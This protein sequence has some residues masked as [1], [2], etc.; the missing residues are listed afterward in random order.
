MNSDG[1]ILNPYTCALT[2][3]NL[4]E[5]GAGTGKTYN[6]Q[7]LVLRKLL[8]AEEISLRNIL[9]VTFT[10]DA[11]AELRTRLRA[12]LQEMK[13][14]CQSGK[15]ISD[16]SEN[17]FRENLLTASAG[18]PGSQDTALE[19]V[20]RALQIF[21]EA[22]IYTIHSFCQRML[23]INA[24]ESGIRYGLEIRTDM[25]RMYQELLHE[26]Y[27]EMLFRHEPDSAWYWKF[28]SLP[29][30]TDFELVNT[31]LSALET[32]MDLAE[33][34]KAFLADEPDFTSADCLEKLAR[35]L[36][37]VAKAIDAQLTQ[38]RDSGN[39]RELLR[40]LRDGQP[41]AE[42]DFTSERLWLLMEKRRIYG[43]DAMLAEAG[44]L[45]EDD[46]YMQ[47]LQELSRLGHIY[48]DLF[49]YC[50]YQ[51][52]KIKCEERKS[53]DNF[54]T[55]NDLLLRMRY[56]LQND[57]GQRLLRA[58][59]QRFV[60]LFLD[61]FQ[62]TDPVQFDIFNRIFGSPRLDG[63]ENCFFMIGDPKQAIYSFRGGD[64]QAYLQAKKFAAHK[65]H[66]LT[67]NYRSSP[68]YITALNNFYDQM[69][70]QSEGA[71]GS[72]SA[73]P[74]ILAE[75]GPFGMLE[76]PWRSIEK[77]P[78]GSSSLTVSGRVL[79][80]E[81]LLLNIE[82]EKKITLEE[83]TVR[84]ISRLVHTGDVR[85]HSSDQDTTGQPL[86]FS[87]IA[88][89]VDTSANGSKV[90]AALLAAGI[91][92]IWSGKS[93]I[94]TSTEAE[95]LEN[96]LAA[97]L[98]P[99]ESRFLK[100]VMLQWPFNFSTGQ[101]ARLEDA[102][103]SL[104]QYFGHLRELWQKRNFLIMFRHFLSHSLPASGFFDPRWGAEFWP[105]ELTVAEVLGANAQGERIL[106]N[107]QHLAEVLYHESRQRHL[108]SE[109]LLNFLRN[110][111]S[112]LQTVADAEA[113][114]NEQLRLPGE[115]DAVLIKTIHKSKGL[116]YPLVILPDLWR[117]SHSAKQC[118]RFH[119]EDGSRCLHVRNADA[120]V[121][122][123]REAICFNE[124]LQ[125]SL[126]LFYVALTRAKFA[127]F[128]LCKSEKT[129]ATRGH[130]SS[131]Y[132][133]FSSRLTLKTEPPECWGHGAEQPEATSTGQTDAADSLALQTFPG[134]FCFQYGWQTCSFTSLAPAH[135]GLVLP[136]TAT[137]VTAPAGSPFPETAWKDDEPLEDDA[138]DDGRT[139]EA[140]EDFPASE[141]PRPAI[142]L[143]PSGKRAGI[144]WHNF[145]EKLDFQTPPAD[146]PVQIGNVLAQNSLL[147]GNP[148][149]REEK[150]SAF[151]DM[152]SGVLQ[153]PLDEQG[154]ICLK[155]VPRSDC[156]PELRFTY[157]LPYGLDSDKFSADLR[158]AGVQM[159]ADW[160]RFY[161][162][163]CNLTGAIDLLFR[164]DG[165]FHILDWKTNFIGGDWDNFSAAG[166][167][168]E[169]DR[170][171]Y[172][173][174][175]IIYVLA[176]FQYLK[177][178]LLE[179][180]QDLDLTEEQLYEKYL[181]SVFYLF[182]RGI[183]WEQ[184]CHGS[185]P[186]QGIYQARPSYELIKILDQYLGCVEFR[187]GGSRSAV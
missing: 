79:S 40:Q 35:P 91:P 177:Q 76:I 17:F 146:L 55:Y 36:Q 14:R 136:G 78:D 96:L 81:E 185:D 120:G 175:Y 1:T 41:E 42:T 174:Q 26:F 118:R 95:L 166:L 93:N 129:G 143:F 88:V 139:A 184:Y 20:E 148:A 52:L 126:R 104:Q 119:A 39:Y 180:Q 13:L 149:Q 122:E 114:K 51:Y 10:V 58:I 23:Q 54:L 69:Q 83:G 12:I 151:C 97:I 171:C 153:V 150:L 116:E 130:S 117:R 115:M 49:L 164:H 128:L 140:D 144:A 168:L 170:N 67:V 77:K 158:S 84:L 160:S 145:F 19:R 141:K 33:E 156:L 85:L 48:R 182:V 173:L 56:A 57:P 101:I 66:T 45:P 59:Q 90:E 106:T 43:L 44:K 157:T 103:P 127:T 28:L 186:R 107:F 5:A 82:L 70:V 68:A 27:R 50:I 21:D 178:R 94:F 37:K 6:I 2:G 47:E 11:A 53:V 113:E 25:L 64:I 132:Q 159:P 161:P 135:Q 80:P 142:F 163:G 187:Q 98:D 24:F 134:N 73:Q 181:G 102:L 63:R 167:E 183:S 32:K 18:I 29:K 133:Y 61:E 87:D 138:L 34:A 165:K 169:M 99:G 147:G 154:R 152:V 125:D 121:N 38:M 124:D 89:L 105:E 108:G 86:K 137:A 110:R 62:D 172:K 31:M 60:A 109:S 162:P 112:G 71:S 65:L 3:R 4:V 176:F 123:D 155:D 72:D 92:V 15:F 7:I 22:P 30:E 75:H 179:N 100:L 111:R 46:P 131:P 74:I 16:Q 9:V 8:Q